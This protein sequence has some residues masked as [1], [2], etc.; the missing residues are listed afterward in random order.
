MMTNNL[1]KNLGSLDMQDL[2]E[3]FGSFNMNNF[4]KQAKILAS[5]IDLT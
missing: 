1:T 5:K 2:P 3:T 4:K